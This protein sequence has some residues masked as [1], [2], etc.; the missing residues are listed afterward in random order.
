MHYTTC[1]HI[2][3]PLLIYAMQYIF[4]THLQ[5][6][7]HTIALW[8]IFY[9]KEIAFCYEYQMAN[10][11]KITGNFWQ[12][13][14]LYFNPLDWGYMWEHKYLN[15]DIFHN[16]TVVSYNIYS[17]NT[18]LF[19]LLLKFERL[20]MMSWNIMTQSCLIYALC[21]TCWHY[22]ANFMK[23]KESNKNKIR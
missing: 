20:S 15:W 9:R 10:A 17:C 19:T 16:H 3:I 12:R 4:N 6:S 18:L 2:Y 23:H 7:M 11:L 14:Y 1:K 13:K 5:N 22:I 21:Y 8:S